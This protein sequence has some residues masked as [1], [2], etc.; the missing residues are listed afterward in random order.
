[1]SN[2]GFDGSVVVCVYSG[3]KQ[4]F[5]VWVFVTLFIS[6]ADGW[7]M[8]IVL[9]TNFDTLGDGKKGGISCTQYIMDI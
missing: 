2:I 5:G 1:M 6:Q 4:S 7:C 3:L 9:T 8:T